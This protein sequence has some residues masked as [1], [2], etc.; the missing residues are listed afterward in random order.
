MLA[1]GTGLLSA[2]AQE[3]PIELLEVEGQ[4]VAQVNARRRSQGREPFAVDMWLTK[5]ARAHSRAMA[6]GKVSFGHGGFQGRFVE[7]K[8]VMSVRRFGENVAY[9]YLQQGDVVAKVVR[10]WMESE[11]HRR[12]ILGDFNV[13]GVG[14]WPAADGKLYFTQLFALIVATPQPEAPPKRMSPF[15]PKGR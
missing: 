7:A 13:T 11:V 9:D 10:R 8:K 12:N 14:V 2:V 5:A 3:P 4:V 15:A 6:L 1:M